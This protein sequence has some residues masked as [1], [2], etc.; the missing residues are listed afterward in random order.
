[1]RFAFSFGQRRQKHRGQNSEDGNND[2]QFDQRETPS[3]ASPMNASIRFERLTGHG[4]RQTKPKALYFVKY[5][6]PVER[7]MSGVAR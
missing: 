2:E 1:M 4:T 6:E 7:Q 5:N 3:D